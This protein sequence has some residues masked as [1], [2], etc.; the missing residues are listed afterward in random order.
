MAAGTVVGPLRRMGD[1]DVLSHVL[2]G[3]EALGA[4]GADEGALAQVDP[5]HV[6]LQ[7]AFLIEGFLAAS[8]LFRAAL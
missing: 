4:E 5:L 6:L 3:G 7:L 2:P 1:F 8:A